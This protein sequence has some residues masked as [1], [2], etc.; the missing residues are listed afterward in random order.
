M[1]LSSTAAVQN[2][3]FSDFLAAE[4]G[5]EKNGMTLSL[6][7]AL[8]RLGMDPWQEAARLAALPEKKAVAA[9]AALIARAIIPAAGAPPSDAPNPDAPGPEAPG[10]DAP[11][12]AERLVQLLPRDGAARASEARPYPTSQSWGSVFRGVPLPRPE[13]LRWW[14][15]AVTLALALLA[16]LIW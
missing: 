3:A 2:G 9:L 13:T 1:R 8:T 11:G 10:P 15:I 12:L 16:N 6:L 4:I 14:A 5:E 7:S